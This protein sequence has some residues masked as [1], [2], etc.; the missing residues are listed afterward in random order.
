MHVGCLVPEPAFCP[1]HHAR[2]PSRA[3]PFRGDLGT[4]S[5]GGRGSLSG[6]AASLCSLPWR[7]ATGTWFLL[8]VCPAPGAWDTGRDVSRAPR[9]AS[10]LGCSELGTAVT[11]GARASRGGVGWLAGVSG[12]VA[13]LATAP[14]CL[15]VAMYPGSPCLSVFQEKLR[16]WI[17]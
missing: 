7:G 6:E 16:I 12:R 8:N 3:A 15:L 11:P 13:T 1:R 2:L 10:F 4:D 17:F 5:S 14:F 9:A